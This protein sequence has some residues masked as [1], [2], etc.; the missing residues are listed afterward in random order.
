MTPILISDHPKTKCLSQTTPFSVWWHIVFL[1]LTIIFLGVIF[2]LSIAPVKVAEGAAGFD[3]IEHFFAYFLFALLT[4]KTTKRAWLAFF[5]AGTYGFLMEAVQ[6]ML[7]YR[8]F[9]L[10]DIAVNYLGGFFLI[11][12]LFCSAKTFK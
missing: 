10:F 9:S 4:Y 5:L 12:V 6:F 7:P 3:K 1:I 11:L 8:S 2:Y